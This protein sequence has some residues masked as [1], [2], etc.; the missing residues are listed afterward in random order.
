[1]NSAESERDSSRPRDW[2]AALFSR[3]VAR[4]DEENS[5]DPR[6]STGSDGEVPYEWLYSQ[7]M[8][9]RLQRFDAGADDALSLAVHAQHL[10]RWRLPRTEYPAGRAGYLE[11]RRRCGEMHAEL[12]SNILREVGYSADD[13]ADVAS[14]LRKEGLGN[15]TRAQTLEDVACLVFLE[16]YALE[17][18]ASLE[19][20]RRDRILR[21]T[22]R[23]MSNKARATAS[24]LP[25]APTVRKLVE[26]LIEE[27]PIEKETEKL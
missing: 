2:S 6:T 20:D 15:D 14:L 17:F 22:W 24:G 18:V 1:M 9:Q 7:R 21:R 4:I 5:R 10:C 27:G 23:K 12:A 13:V 11:W 3:A 16:S 19:D 8:S 26:A 25:L